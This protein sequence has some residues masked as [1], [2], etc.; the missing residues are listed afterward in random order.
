MSR[1]TIQLGEAEL[2]AGDPVLAGLVR[3]A[4]PCPLGGRR[5]RSHF[6]ALVRSIVFQQLAGR[7][8]A[9]I[10]GRLLALFDGGVPTPGSLLA[11]PE[12]R[13][14]RAGLS[15]GKVAS[16]RD[17]AARSLDGT[18]PLQGLGRLAD[19]Q[20]VERLS[21]VRGIGTWTAEMFLMFQLGRPDV[22]PVGDL[23]VR[24]GYALAY[25]LPAAPTPAE[26]GPLGD[27]F[28]PWRSVA[29]WYCWQAVH[30]TRGEVT[31]R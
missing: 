22:W 16:L 20:V 23:G 5:H 8:A 17:L 13:L 11:V 4:G 24:S 6:E 30:L 25:S 9:A 2:A 3:A 27:R 29:A 28:R 14:R 19:D 15:G 18:V 26:L 1:A 10:H 7:A 31:P 12:D 21:A